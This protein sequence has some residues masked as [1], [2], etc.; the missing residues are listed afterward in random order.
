MK[1]LL[2][3]VLFVSS[4]QAFAQQ[5][6]L[7]K[8]K[9]IIQKELKTLI[10]SYK[11]YK[12]EEFKFDDTQTRT[13]KQDTS[14]LK[15]IKVTQEDAC[16]LLYIYNKNKN[17]AIDLIGG[18]ARLEYKNGKYIFEDGEDGGHIYLH[19]FKDKKTYQIGYNSFST[20]AEEAFWLTENTFIIAISINEDGTFVTPSIYY[21]DIKEN[22]LY[23]FGNNNK[24]CKSKVGSY[25][26]KKILELEKKKK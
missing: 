26:S 18:Q 4:L 23:V 16:A 25:T 6:L 1:F 10:A 24:K 8:N 22:K 14:D 9:I 7:I 11:N 19:N 3:I 17:L 5:D 12:L 15:A 21:G 20:N 13:L 2:A